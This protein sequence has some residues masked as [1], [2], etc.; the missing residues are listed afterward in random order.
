LVAAEMVRTAWVLAALVTDCSTP[1]VSVHKYWLPPTVEG[2][3]PRPRWRVNFN[4][5]PD[6]ETGGRRRSTRKG[7]TRERAAKVFDDEVRAGVREGIVPASARGGVTVA[8]YLRSWYAGVGGK[9]TTR[10]HYRDMCEWYL[11]PLLG[12]LPFAKLD[13]PDAPELIDVAYRALEAGGWQRTTKARTKTMQPLS[14]KTIRL[15]HV[16]LHRALAVAVERGRLRRNPASLAHP[17]STKA[18]RSRKAERVWTEE[19]LQQ[20][21]GY[22]TG[23]RLFGVWYLAMTTGMRRGELAGLHWTLVDLD[24]ARLKVRWELTVVDNRPVWVDG[25]KSEAGERTIDLD[26]GTVAALKHHRAQLASERLALGSSYEQQ[27]PCPQDHGHDLVVCWP[28]GRQMHPNRLLR[29]LYRHAKAL[30]LPRIDVHGLRHSY[31]TIALD[32]GVDA[33]TVSERL[34]HDVAV[35]LGT[36]RHVSERQHREAAERIAKRITG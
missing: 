4:L 34:G 7:F 2:G 25:A 22:L 18:T 21:I 1:S 8:G 10:Q 27:C 24:A 35:T 3:K 6:P 15:A 26:A 12:G 14:P 11:I 36:Y 5:P 32:M 20:W 33:K 28:D 9:A 19:Q 30:D 29:A 16:V 31:A 13:A 17:P 23:D